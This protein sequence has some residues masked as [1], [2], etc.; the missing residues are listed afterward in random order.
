MV[1]TFAARVVPLVGAPVLAIILGV[2]I[3]SMRRDPAWQP[4]LSDAGRRWL[5]YGIVI[6]GFT[7][8]LASVLKT[9]VATLPLIVITIAV[10]LVLAVPLG[11]LLGVARDTRDLVGAGTAIC[12]ASAIAAISSVID[13]PADAI[14]LSV[15][16]VFFYNVVAV[17]VFPALGHAMAMSQTQ[18]GTWAGTAINDTSSVVAAGYAFG[19]VAGAQATIVKLTRATMILPLAA[20]YAFVRARKRR[21]AGEPIAWRAIVPWFILWFLAAALAE[22]LVP[23]AWHAGIAAAGVFLI[24]VA[25]AAIGLRTNVAALA[26]TGARPLALGFL[27]WLSVAVSALIVQHFTGT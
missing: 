1:A 12:G 10:A 14:A 3:G 27:L 13:A 7:L 25:L 24:T 21:A 19:A 17:L 6:T 4:G 15:A 8:P 23:Q 11:R 16:T 9:G 18:F 20:G 26:R 5:Q 2:L 22:P